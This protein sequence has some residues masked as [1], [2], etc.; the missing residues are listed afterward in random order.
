M[1]V[2]CCGELKSAV[3]TWVAERLSTHG[4]FMTAFDALER[5]ENIYHRM[6]EA[7]LS[8]APPDA[9]EILYL[10]REF[11]RACDSFLAALDSETMAHHRSL[12]TS[13]KNAIGT[14]RIRLMSYTMHWQPS[15]IEEM[16]AAYHIAAEDMA[17]VVWSV[18]SSARASLTQAI[19]R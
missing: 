14:L 17:R 16:P 13:L 19:M 5:I 2:E 10:R 9:S 7:T 15:R 6:I 3:P 1:I 12:A 18:I 4:Y 11:A 8:E